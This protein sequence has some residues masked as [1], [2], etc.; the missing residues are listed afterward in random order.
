MA[1]KQSRFLKQ[2]K[3]GVGIGAMLIVG[4]FLYLATILIQDAPMGEFV[5]GEHYT[6]LEKPRRIRGDRVEIMEFFS[7]GCVHC[8]NFDDDIESWVQARQGSINFIRTP[9]FSNEQWRIFG[10]T[11]FTL[12]ELEILEENHYSFFRE[13]HDARKKLDSLDNIA[14][15]FAT[16]DVS[17]EAF[18]LAFNSPSVNQ[19]V[20]RADQL[21]RRFK[22]ASVPNIII[23]GKYLVK[24]N[25]NVGLSRMLDVMD[26]LIEKEQ[27]SPDNSSTDRLQG[28]SG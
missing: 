22:I 26:F 21:G 7:Y 24:I 8:Y 1:G 18:R 14:N 25:N 5:E 16:E 15:F 17:V 6:L 4:I 28:K 3:V 20:N 11:Y 19:K 27:A 2:Q 13:I 12:E 10:R 9:V 23:N